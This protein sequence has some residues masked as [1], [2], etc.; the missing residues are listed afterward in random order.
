[1]NLYLAY[2]ISILVFIL[3]SCFFSASETAIISANKNQLRLL[4][5]RGSRNAARALSLIE[6]VEVAVGM[7]LVGNNIVNLASASFVAFIATKYFF[8][9]ETYL[10]AITTAQ[11]AVFLVCCEILP[12]VVAR[13]MAESFLMNFSVP[14]RMFIWLFNPAIRLS[15]MLTD[16]MKKR[17]NMGEGGATLVNSRDEIG[18]LFKLGVTEGIIHKSHNDYIS[19]ILSLQETTVI[20]VMTPIIE[21]VSVERSSTIRE[22]VEVIEKTR[23][24][25]LPV[26]ENRVD[27]IIGFVYYRD[28]MNRKSISS[29]DSILRKA[30]YVPSTKRLDR[31]FFDMNENETQMVFVV[32]EYGGVEGLV[33]MEDIVEEVIG[34]IHTRDHPDNIMIER[35][36]S[37]KY[38]MK[39]NIDIDF[40]NREFGTCIEKKGFETL[41]GFLNYH[42]GRIP[43]PGDRVKIDGVTM[44][45]EQAGERAAE[46]VLLT[47]SRKKTGA[48]ENRKK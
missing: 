15:L 1:M 21:I 14:L 25:R 39:P 16:M 36:G 46:R 43:F 12:K 11:T 33:T 3:L 48:P 2:E 26:Y 47:L 13:S 32:N 29:I 17:F 27:N 20:E 19:D 9:T 6:D 40:F 24:S 37:R 22:L 35:L 23:F 5:G 44:T 38:R 30:D 18:F 10:I 8:V 4:A 42:F 7:T 28:L 41:S 34:D 31:L 45:V